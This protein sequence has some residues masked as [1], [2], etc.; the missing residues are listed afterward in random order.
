MKTSTILIPALLVSSFYTSATLAHADND[1]IKISNTAAELIN[2]KNKPIIKVTEK[3][4][5]GRSHITYDNFNVSHA[6]L[7]INNEIGSNI[8]INEVISDNPT[9]LNGEIQIT[10]H[11]A[12]LMIVN[13][14]GITCSACNFKNAIN[15][16]LIVGQIKDSKRPAEWGGDHNAKITII[17]TNKKMSNIILNGKN[18]EIINSQLTFDSLTFTNM[19]STIKNGTM[20]S[21]VFIDNESKIKSGNIKLSLMDT[22]FTNN[23]TINSHFSGITFHSNLENNGYIYGDY[24]VFGEQ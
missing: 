6:G 22:I 4:S 8:I 19:K 13:Q 24:S 11:P 12:K 9:M 17:D 15:T 20:K 5:D 1:G 2:G 14:N 7:I 16:N 21:R 18:I 10:E 3:N 23:G